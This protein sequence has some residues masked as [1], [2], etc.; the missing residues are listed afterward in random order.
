MQIFPKRFATCQGLGQALGLE[1]QEF[2]PS[3]TRKSLI[4]SFILEQYLGLTVVP[5]QDS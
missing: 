5:L 4:N 2:I 3:F 1:L